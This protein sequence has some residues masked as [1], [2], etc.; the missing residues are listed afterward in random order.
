MS[1]K[2]HLSHNLYQLTKGYVKKG[3]SVMSRSLLFAIILVSS[4]TAFTEYHLIVVNWLPVNYAHGFISLATPIRIIALLVYGYF[5]L[6]FS[7]RK[8][9]DL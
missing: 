2:S 8:L 9:N 1:A 6:R 7:H 4:L 3:R 5:G